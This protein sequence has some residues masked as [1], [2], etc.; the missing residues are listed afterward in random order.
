MVS[1][2]PSAGDDRRPKYHLRVAAYGALD[3]ANSFLGLAIVKA[4]KPTGAVLR[5]I[6]NDLFDLGADLCRPERERVKVEP[7]R[8]VE[9]QVRW[10]ERMIDRVNEAL[11]PLNS[12][13]LPGGAEPSA[14][15]HVARTIVRRAERDIVDLAFEDAVNPMVIRYV[16]RLSD[17]LFALAR[18]EN[19]G[20]GDIP[21]RP[22]GYRH[23]G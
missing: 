23:E 15:L 18:V 16:S 8:V 13:I 3:E 2:T 12:F 11:P 14:L 19:A 21:W 6:Q 9:T 10:V 17:L 4:S 1:Y 22:G 5:R 20:T 7:M